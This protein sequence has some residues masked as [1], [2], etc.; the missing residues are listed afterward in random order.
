M[1]CATLQ[2]TVVIPADLVDMTRGATAIVRGRVIDVDA[3]WTGDR[4]RIE[5]LVRLDVEEYLKGNLGD[6]VTF[7]VPGG[8]IGYT[9]S[10]FVGAPTF[11][12]GD[13]VVLFLS[14]RGPSIPYVFGLSQGVFRIVP[15]AAGEPVVLPPALMRTTGV[16]A[17]RRGDPARRPM[18]VADFGRLVRQVLAEG[19]R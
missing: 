19:A 18:P 13:Q 1:A 2:A 10:M 3:R 12:A 15:G 9:R 17:I 6:V 4:R 8:E 16:Q 5:S 11:R 7:K 14:A